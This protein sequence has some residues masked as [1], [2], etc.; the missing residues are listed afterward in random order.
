MLTKHWLWPYSLHELDDL[1]PDFAATAV[2]DER[3]NPE[4]DLTQGCGGVVIIRCVQPRYRIVVIKVRAACSD[5]LTISGTYV[6]ARHGPTPSQV[7]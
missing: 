6:H 3:L 4:S 1:H 5:H 2:A 7:Y